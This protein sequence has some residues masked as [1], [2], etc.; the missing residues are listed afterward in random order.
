MIQESCCDLQESNHLF[1]AKRFALPYIR[2]TRRKIFDVTPYGSRGYV[3]ISNID[4]TG[5]P[6]DICRYIK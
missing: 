3:N 4:I 2:E 6:S 1:Q 5:I